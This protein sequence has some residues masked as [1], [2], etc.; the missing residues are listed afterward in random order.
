M[1]Y[2]QDFNNITRSYWQITW[3]WPV[4]A[5]TCSQYKN[6]VKISQKQYSYMKRTFESSLVLYTIW[7]KR[8]GAHVYKQERNDCA[9]E[10]VL[11]YALQLCSELEVSISDSAYALYP[12]LCAVGKCQQLRHP[13]ATSGMSLREMLVSCATLRNEMVFHE[14]T[15]KYFFYSLW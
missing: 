3:K 13:T 2:I 11:S 6:L 10:A 14:V 12:C 5:K 7:I 8:E 9:S 1:P 4:K 15:I